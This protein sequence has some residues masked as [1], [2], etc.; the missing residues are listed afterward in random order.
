MNFE[1]LYSPIAEHKL[2]SYKCQL[3]IITGPKYDFFLF[4]D[5]RKPGIELNFTSHDFGPSFVT[6]QPMSKTINLEVIN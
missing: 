6:N 5:A 2:K 1:I 4:G 3:D